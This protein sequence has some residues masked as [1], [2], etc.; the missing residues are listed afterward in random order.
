MSTL[1]ELHANGKRRGDAPRVRSGIA[2]V[3]GGPAAP[4]AHGG[5]SLQVTVDN[6]QLMALGYVYQTSTSM[7]A[8]RSI[9]MGQLLS[10]GI[11]VR[12]SG[13]DVQ[14]TEQFSRHLESVWI[15]FARDVIDSF[16]QFG[17]AVVSIE[18][19][20]PPP[21]AT[22]LSKAKRSKSAASDASAAI[23]SASAQS[24][25]VQPEGPESSNAAE[26]AYDR[27]EKELPRVPV[28]ADVGSYHVS[29]RMGGRRGYKREYKVS[30]V[31]SSSELMVDDEA[32]VFLK[33]PPD[34][35][36]NVNSPVATAF[37]LAHF[38]T[39]LTD[40]ALKA[41][42]VRSRM[43]LVTQPVQKAG[44]T[45]APLDAASM[46][47]DDESRALATED[48]HTNSADQ[49]K[50]L[51]LCAKLCTVLNHERTTHQADQSAAG[52]SR[53]APAKPPLP[54]EVPPRVFCVPRDQEVV[55]A[56]R[57]PEARSDLES[58]V[59][60][61]NDSICAVMGVPASVVFEGK[62]SSNSM[63]QLQLL[64]TTVQSLAIT[65]NAV[66]TQCYLVCFSDSTSAL[67]DE[68][69]LLTAPLSSVEEIVS[70]VGAGVIDM[71]SALP[72]SLHSLGASANEI[73]AALD[74]YR[75]KAEEGRSIDDATQVTDLA[76]KKASVDLTV[77]QV[78]KTKADAKSAQT[79][80]KQAATSSGL[81][82]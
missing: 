7:Q 30:A 62:F 51:A 61:A 33:T 44:A 48:A 77:A 4:L 55:P 5:G 49:A 37:E 52:G 54:P 8:A 29:F 38:V 82:K 43:Q 41:E 40:F 64:N 67:T 34:A 6:Q 27:L 19:Q 3:F 50:H 13:K 35:L 10:S 69:C 2:A 24:F 76:Q 17:F 16:L 1:K 63:S 14:L 45:N 47:F 72:S 58:L 9:M 75:A 26:P 71:E 70:L 57:P 31:S 36:G 46:F 68:L 42:S 79:A 65:V 18:E 53:A 32:A 11:V 80:G 60:V 73:N 21:F 74:R 25:H 22:H 12:R 20:T 66:L 78:E 28:V 81:A 59:R 39:T 56:I 15:P 23:A